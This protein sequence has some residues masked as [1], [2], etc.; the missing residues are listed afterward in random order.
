MSQ[1]DS[2]D[3][4]QHRK[5]TEGRPDDQKSIDSATWMD[6]DELKLLEERE[7]RLA[8]NREIEANFRA[9]IKQKTSLSEHSITKLVNIAFNLIVEKEELIDNR[10]DVIAKYI[11]WVDTLQKEAEKSQND[12]ENLQI[13]STSSPPPPMIAADGNQGVQGPPTDMV[14]FLQEN[15]IDSVEELQEKLTELNKLKR[16]MKLH[17]NLQQRRERIAAASSSD[18]NE[19]PKQDLSIVK[20]LRSRVKDLELDKKLLEEENQSLKTSSSKKKMLGR[21]EGEKLGQSK[22]NEEFQRQD[23]ARTGMKGSESKKSI[24]ARTPGEYFL[25]KERARENVCNETMNGFSPEY[26]GEEQKFFGKPHYQTQWDMGRSSEMAIFAMMQQMRTEDRLPEPPKY[27][28]EEKSTS[29]EAFIRIF[30]LKYGRLSDEQQVILLEANFLGGKALKVFRS[31]PEYEKE[32]FETVIAAMS[33]RLRV[34]E[35]DESHRAKTR[36]EQLRRRDN[37]TVEDYCLALDELAKRA[38]VGISPRQIA[39]IKIAELLSAIA[40]NEYMA[41]AV[42]DKIDDLPQVEQYEAARKKA[43]RMERGMMERE[44]I[45]QEAS[46]SAKKGDKKCNGDNGRSQQDSHQPKKSFIPKDNRNG[47]NSPSQNYQA[48]PSNKNVQ[49]SSSSNCPQ[50]FPSSDN[51]L[52]QSTQQSLGDNVYQAVSNDEV[53]QSN[54]DALGFQGCG[55]CK[56]VGFHEPSCS[57][58]PRGSKSCFVCQSPDHF[59]RSCPQK[60]ASKQLSTD[61]TRYNASVSTLEYVASS[62]EVNAWEEGKICRSKCEEGK[63]AGVGV[64]LMIDSGATVSIMSEDMWKHIVKVKGKEWERNAVKEPVTQNV[65]AANNELI[66]MLFVVVLETSLRCKT[67]KIP[68]CVAKVSRRNVILGFNNFEALGIQLCFE[69][70][71]RSI[72][73]MRDILLAP[74]SQEIVEVWVEGY[75][76]DQRCCIVYPLIDQLSA[77]VCQVSKNG[78][79]FLMLCNSGEDSVMLE[80]SQV[81]AQ[82]EIKELEKLRDEVS[83]ESTEQVCP[84]TKEEVQEE[85]VTRSEHIENQLI[86][87]ESM[88]VSRSTRNVKEECELIGKKAVDIELCQGPPLKSFINSSSQDCLQEDKIPDHGNLIISAELEPDKDHGSGRVPVS[89]NVSPDPSEKE[90]DVAV[91]GVTQTQPYSRGK[92]ESR[93]GINSSMRECDA[94]YLSTKFRDQHQH[95]IQEQ[96]DPQMES[97]RHQGVLSPGNDPPGFANLPREPTWP[98]KDPTPSCQPQYEHHNDPPKRQL[99]YD[100]GSSMCLHSKPSTSAE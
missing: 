59:A 41:S 26:G 21:I 35:A 63:I 66:K 80:K 22:E 68:I 23:V 34:S 58:A 9:E 62:M 48:N 100:Q 85:R 86:E 64:E 61:V 97:S 46:G 13:P 27:T 76:S 45:R 82:G 72:R 67:T 42:Q 60:V 19:E 92:R 28:A 39:S 56:R 24:E 73:L 25:E 87:M 90:G 30:K 16:E 75:F 91:G 15:E 7:V 40:S 83:K 74:R 93:P 78:K 47:F 38:F 11:K 33:D 70:N 51:Q 2:G 52:S 29:L 50:S 77:S 20:S 4:E 57:K 96:A 12:A 44:K 18:S 69:D 3:D 17:H 37:E 43:I 84:V 65:R 79:S 54:D 98:L 88:S 8:K 1:V 49:F 36:W 95:I 14:R 94:R 5:E 32:S 89:V 6:I 71:H 55:E 10:E 53:K 31:I 81:I 99:Q